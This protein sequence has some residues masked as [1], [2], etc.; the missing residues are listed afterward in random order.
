MLYADYEKY[1]RDNYTAVSSAN[2]GY[3]MATNDST[4]EMTPMPILACA[5]MQEA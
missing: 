5:S 3:A 4:I 2:P 1:Y